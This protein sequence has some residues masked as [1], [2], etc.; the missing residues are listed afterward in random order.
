MDYLYGETVFSSQ[1]SLQT[2]SGSFLDLI[3][4]VHKW[5]AVNFSGIQ[6]LVVL[7]QKYTD[8]IWS[9]LGFLRTCFRIPTVNKM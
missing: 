3:I 8:A 7:D 2:V 9:G 1:I 4:Q 6:Q 5:E